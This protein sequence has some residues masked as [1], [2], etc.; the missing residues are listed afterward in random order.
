MLTHHMLGATWPPRAGGII[1]ISDIRGDTRLD[2]VVDIRVDIR[3]DIV[4]DIRVDMQTFGRHSE[5]W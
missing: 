2:I 1:E 5:L 4:G 3:V